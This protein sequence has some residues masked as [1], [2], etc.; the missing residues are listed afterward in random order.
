MRIPYVPN[1]GIKFLERENTENKVN[2]YLKGIIYIIIYNH[3]YAF[4]KK[5]SNFERLLMIFDDFFL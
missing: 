5:D 2:I 3:F 1:R 4:G